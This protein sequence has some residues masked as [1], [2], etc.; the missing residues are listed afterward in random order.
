MAERVLDDARASARV[1]WHGIDARRQG[2]A[3]TIRTR[4][5][6]AGHAGLKRTAHVCE[7]YASTPA[8]TMQCRDVLGC[9]R[10]DHGYRLLTDEAICARARDDGVAFTCRPKPST[11]ERDAIRI[12]AIK[13]MYDAGPRS[14]WRP[15]TRNV[16]DRHR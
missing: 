15:T 7:D 1:R 14:R 12:G 13:H 11:R 8:T 6:R 2:T 9:E 5:Q 4:L 3:R 10:L 16:R